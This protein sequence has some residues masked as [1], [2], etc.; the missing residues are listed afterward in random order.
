MK[1]ILAVDGGNS[2][3]HAVIVNDAGELLGEGLSL[4]SNYTS[5]GSELFLTHLHGAVN[6]ALNE[7]DLQSDD[8]DY[9]QYGL[10]GAD[11]AKDMKVLKKL[12]GKMPFKQWGL[13]CDTL[14]GLRSGSP[15]NIGVVLICGSGTNAAGIDQFG[16]RVQI[17]GFGYKFGDA[18]GG[19]FMAQ[20]TFRMAIRSWESRDEKSMLEEM[21]PL[22]LGF[23]DME[24]LYH[25][26]LETE[27]FSAPLQLTRVLHRAA[28]KGDKAAIMILR[29]IGEELGK[30][31][32][33]V[34]NRL[35]SL[36]E[37][38]IPIVLNGSVLQKG[39]NPHL[40]NC[41]KETLEYSGIHNYEL[42]NLDIAP[43]YGSVFLTFDKLG[44]KVTDEQIKSYKQF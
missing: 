9:A 24:E 36:L 6:Q 10:A 34:V 44:I 43:V 19:A 2:K 35:P 33:A 14:Q 13:E 25:F 27:A 31:G 7:A 11:T 32:K 20:E 12:V 37:I 18:A 28:E 38:K 30:A 16:N 29:N 22:E 42:I 3:T 39:K 15:K 21:V 17:G 5:T 40:I 4:G 8:I 41:L 23:S 1:K 26:A